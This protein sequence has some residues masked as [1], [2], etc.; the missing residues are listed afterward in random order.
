MLNNE[1]IHTL[2][3]NEILV[4]KKFAE[5]FSKNKFCEMKEYYEM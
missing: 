2:F 4:K 1:F 5:I 3:A